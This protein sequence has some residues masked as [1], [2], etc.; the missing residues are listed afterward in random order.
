[1]QG[2]LPIYIANLSIWHMK[3]TCPNSLLA[4]CQQCCEIWWCPREQVITHPSSIFQFWSKSIALQGTF[5]M[6]IAN[7]SIVHIKYT[8]PSCLLATCQ[9]SGERAILG[10]ME[11]LPT[12]IF[13]YLPEQSRLGYS[14][15]VIAFRILSCNWWADSLPNPV[16][17]FLQHGVVC[18]IPEQ[19]IILLR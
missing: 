3:W 8:W 18:T 6:L 10:L 11:K 14:P 2:T 5:I 15:A 17:P 12:L 19:P 1:M 13:L 7:L 4:T 9:W 16:L